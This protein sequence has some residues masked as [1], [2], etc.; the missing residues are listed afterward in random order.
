M[1]IGMLVGYKMHK[2]LGRQATTSYDSNLGEII[3]IINSKYVDA[4]ATDSI[5]TATI[6]KLLSQLDPHSVYIPPQ[7]LKEVDEDLEGEFDGIGIEFFIQKDTLVVTSVI[8][9]GP[10]EKAGVLTGD[11]FIKVNDSIIAGN[12]LS[13]EAIIKLLKGISGTKVKVTVLRNNKLIAPI[14]ITRGTIPLLSIDA[15]YMMADSIGYI[16]IN[17]FAAHTHDEF[18][19]GLTML[20]GKGMQH[21]IIDLQGNPGGYLTE[22]VSIVDE[23]LPGTS[24]VVYTKGRNKS[25]EEYTT[26]KA[27]LFE[28]GKLCIL[29][30][31]GSASAAEILSGAVQDNDRGIIIGR[32]SFGKGLVQEQYPLNNGGALRL[33]VARYYIP[34]GRCIQKDYSNGN[35]AYDQ[36][37][38]NRYTQGELTSLQDSLLNK[39]TTVYKTKGGRKVYGGG[40]ITPDVFTLLDTT[41]YNQAL[42]EVLNSALPNEVANNYYDTHSHELKKYKSTTAFATQFTISPELLNNLKNKCSLNDITTKPFNKQ[43]DI[44]IIKT[45][46]TAI[47]AKRIYGS[48]A[49]FEVENAHNT[50]IAEAIKQF[51]K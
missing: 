43:K 2:T 28:Q 33:T 40:G 25:K 35:E 5:E 36:E 50:M 19:K 11:K 15:C 9:S 18:T 10:S 7:D 26:N 39:D 47:L 38:Y 48:Q 45:R 31:E 4:V 8:P 51:K 17:R 41:L 24:T 46:L 34:S 37:L 16:K 23:L 3:N 14:A 32:R 6:E 30:N 1:A 29:I 20:K 44:D 12:K 49:W 13:N 42:I 21:L 22:A 27:G